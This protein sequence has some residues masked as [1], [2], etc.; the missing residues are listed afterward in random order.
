MFS[1]RV[2]D[3]PK[4]YCKISVWWA[5]YKALVLLFPL[6]PSILS[7]CSG[8]AV[9]GSANDKSCVQTIAVTDCV[10]MAGAILVANDRDSRSLGPARSIPSLILWVRSFCFGILEIA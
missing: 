8:L 10:F 5:Q 6:T 1:V 2:S 3:H 7:Y 4:Y 9:R